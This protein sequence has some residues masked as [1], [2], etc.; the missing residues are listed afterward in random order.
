MTWDKSPNTKRILD[1]F[2]GK[3]GGS[4]AV[5]GLVKSLA[6]ASLKVKNAFPLNIIS[7]SP[8]GHFKTRLSV[9]QFSIFGK[10]DIVD[11]G[12][13]F[14]I[15]GIAEQYDKGRKINNKTCLINDLTLLFG[16]KSK[17]A[18]ERLINALAELLSEGSYGYKNFRGNWELNARIS[19]IGNVTIDSYMKYYKELIES[20]FGERCLTV[21]YIVDDD[22]SS[23]FSKENEKRIGMVFGDRVNIRRCVVDYRDFIDK[24]CEMAKPWR[25]MSLSPSLTRTFDRIVSIA[26]SNAVLNGRQ[27]VCDEDLVVLGLVQA[28]LMNPLSRHSDI[29]QLAVKGLTQNEICKR[30]GKDP[31]SYQ[32]YVSRVIGE[33][34]GK[35][36]IR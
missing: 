16:S 19:L 28:Y 4:V 22:D 21:F 6:V 10:R 31:S 12:S 2:R 25:L 14:T 24:F 15:H 30:L 27:K 26:C 3:Y 17:Q 35:G 13:D 29:I 20:T 34:K 7:V 18:K 9:E 36:V 33:Y 23:K 11:F 5:I 8:A 32:G 1:Y